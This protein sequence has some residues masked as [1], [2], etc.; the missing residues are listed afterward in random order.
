MPRK[1]ENIYKRKDGR[2]EGR[3]IVAR[4]LDGTA[5]YRSVYGKTYTEVKRKLQREKALH[6]STIAK[7]SS[8]TK[9]SQRLSQFTIEWL[10]S[11]KPKIKEASW[12][13]YCNLVER[14][15]LPQLGACRPAQLTFSKIEAFAQHL[16]LNGGINNAALSA[17]TVMDTLSV[18]KGVIP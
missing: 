10:Q 12:N 6:P 4:F 7:M 11:M 16:L 2:W 14:Y 1:G 17:K 13:K 5:K 8:P 18:I 15:I 3:L 9:E